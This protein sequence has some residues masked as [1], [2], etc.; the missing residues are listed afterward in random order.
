MPF[1]TITCP[2]CGLVLKV[3]REAGAS[4]LVFDVNDWRRRCKRLHF[5]DPVLCLEMCDGTI[6]KNHRPQ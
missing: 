1:K 5:D 4:S 3:T 2:D 6:S